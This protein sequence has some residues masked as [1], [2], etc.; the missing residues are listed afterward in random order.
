MQNDKL[1]HFVRALLIRLTAFADDWFAFV[2]MDERVN[3][4]LKDEE[5][6]M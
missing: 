3:I 2:G 5:Q 4:C 6:K 1:L